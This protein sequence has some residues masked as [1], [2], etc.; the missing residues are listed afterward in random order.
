MPI[1]TEEIE[2]VA[3]RMCRRKREFDGETRNALAGGKK[4]SQ[5]RE[6]EREREKD[7]ERERE[8][9]LK[10]TTYK[11]TCGMVPVFYGTSLRI[12]HREL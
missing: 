6:R 8:L 10:F 5:D 4:R 11:H 3:K 9:I 2:S 1:T 7:R 12:A